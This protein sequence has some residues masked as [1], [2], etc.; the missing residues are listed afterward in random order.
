MPKIKTRG[1]VSKRF[2]L[3]GSGKVVRRRAGGT[4]LRS[5]KSESTKRLGNTPAFVVG[6]LKKNIK[7]ALGV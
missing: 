5:K 1:S 3:T 6:A 2:K 7:R 4:H